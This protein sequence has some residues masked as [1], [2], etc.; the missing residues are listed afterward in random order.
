MN[1]LKFSFFP[2]IWAPFDFQN[3][4]DYDWHAFPN[5]RR[6]REIL[7]DPSTGQKYERYNIDVEQIGDAPLSTSLKQDV[8]GVTMNNEDN[9]FDDQ[10]EEDI[11]D[12]KSLNDFFSQQQEAPQ[13]ENESDDF[14]LSSSRWLAYD[15]LSTMLDR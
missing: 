2:D 13:Q 10:F 3:N 4:S 12:Q 5:G 14:D 9:E 6:R 11:Q 1:Q 15:T 7:T 8:N